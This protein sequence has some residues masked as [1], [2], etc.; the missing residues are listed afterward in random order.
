MCVYSYC[1][2]YIFLL[3]CLRSF[4]VSYVLFCVFCFHFVILCIVGVQM[5]NVLLPTG[6][7]PITVNKY[8]IYRIL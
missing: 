2:V 4:I 5:R 7:N 3:L 1:Y 6:V 8:I